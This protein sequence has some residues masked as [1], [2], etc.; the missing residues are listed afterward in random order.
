MPPTAN[1]IKDDFER[2][3]DEKIDS[4]THMLV[5]DIKGDLNVIKSNVE[6]TR[7]TIEEL[8]NILLNPE[9]GIYVKVRSLEKTKAMW[10]KLFW[11]IIT[12]SAGAISYIL[13]H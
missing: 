6:E 1:K 8:R 11:I 2:I 9:S 5:S 4:F 13:L 10:T 12:T 3:L 7:E